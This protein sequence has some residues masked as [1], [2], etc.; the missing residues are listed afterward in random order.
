MRKVVKRR[1]QRQEKELERV[2]LDR[3]LGLFSPNLT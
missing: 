1:V 3:K 2:S